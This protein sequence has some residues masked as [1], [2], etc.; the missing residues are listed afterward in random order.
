LKNNLF[1][2]FQHSKKLFLASE[3]NLN[4]LTHFQVTLGL[5]FKQN[6]YPFGFSKGNMYNH[7]LTGE[8]IGIGL[9]TKKK[10]IRGVN[11]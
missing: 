3:Q 5:V 2:K 10:T 4:K 7:P 8:F 11:L 1:L 9:S 6:N